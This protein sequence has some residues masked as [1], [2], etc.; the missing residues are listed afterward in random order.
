MITYAKINDT[1][2]VFR[3]HIDEGLTD[4]ASVRLWVRRPDGA[5][6]DRDCDLEIIDGCEFMGSY[7]W[8]DGDLDEP[9]LYLTEMIITTA[10]GKIT[11]EPSTGFWP[12]HVEADLPGSTS[13][14]L[15][16]AHI[17]AF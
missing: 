8:Q 15:V 13:S 3:R 11:H 10:T 1:W 16:K 2:P 5:L 12:I 14:D 17:T 6:L 7:A 9:G 4:A